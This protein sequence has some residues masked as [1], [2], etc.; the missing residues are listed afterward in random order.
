MF[1]A[2]LLSVLLLLGGG[3]NNPNPPPTSPTITVDPITNGVAVGIFFPIPYL[4]PDVL[5]IDIYKEVGE[6]LV[7]EQSTSWIDADPPYSTPFYP[8]NHGNYVAIATWQVNGAT[9]GT[10]HS[11]NW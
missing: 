3:P 9:F 10:T 7:L 5:V 4:L 1:K 6:E 8:S 11:F 2:I